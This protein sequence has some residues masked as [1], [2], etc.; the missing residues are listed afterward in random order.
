MLAE[1]PPLIDITVTSGPGEQPKI[2]DWWSVGIAI[3]ALFVA[4]IAAFFNWKTNQNQAKQLASLEQENAERKQQERRHQASRVWAVIDDRLNIIVRNASEL[5]I[6]D[7]VT[8]YIG[9]HGQEAFDRVDMIDPE[10][11]RLEIGGSQKSISRQI[12]RSIMGEGW[13][14]DKN[15]GLYFRSDGSFKETYVEA[16]SLGKE[17]IRSGATVAFRDANNQ[18]WVRRPNGDLESGSA[19]E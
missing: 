12:D 8:S 15:V 5:P 1:I 18:T 16:R 17:V 6:Y 11:S 2:T 7:V 13:N 4:S 10:H 19:G 9:P 14:P 3:G